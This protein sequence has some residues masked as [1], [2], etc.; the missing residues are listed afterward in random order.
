[1]VLEYGSMH[2][3]EILLQFMETFVL[4]D[5]SYLSNLAQLGLHELFHCYI[6]HSYYILDF[7]FCTL[8]VDESSWRSW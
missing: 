5:D 7:H 8:I 1:M 6:I 3:L 2:I 4:F